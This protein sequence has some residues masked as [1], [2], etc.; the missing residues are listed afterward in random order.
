M[1]TVLAT[2]LAD[3]YKPMLRSAYGYIRENQVVDELPHPQRYFRD[4]SRGGWGFGNYENG[5]P[6]ADCTSEAVKSVLE[7]ESLVENPISE[8][9]LR[10][11]VRLILSGQ[12]RDGGWATYER[13]RGGRWL[14]QLNLSQVFRDIVVDYS[15]P[16]C[17][18]SCIQMLVDW[19]HGG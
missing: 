17:T 4:P 2:P 7:L 13:R 14:E 1:Q 18:S 19:P 9:L 3:I 15:Y 6:V 10:A 11:S 5:W 12:N 8:D 16:E